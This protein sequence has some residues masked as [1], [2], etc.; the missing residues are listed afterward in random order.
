MLVSRLPHPF[1]SKSLSGAWS[2]RVEVMSSEHLLGPA[3]VSVL[4]VIRISACTSFPP[5]SGYFE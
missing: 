3:V 2:D 5:A 4:V 1:F